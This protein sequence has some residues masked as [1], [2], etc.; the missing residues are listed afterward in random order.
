MIKQTVICSVSDTI[1]NRVNPVQ[2]LIKICG[3]R[4]FKR[5]HY[6]FH[7]WLSVRVYHLWYNRC[8]KV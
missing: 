2:A 1:G 4:N 6:L 8:I 5:N 3:E 7:L